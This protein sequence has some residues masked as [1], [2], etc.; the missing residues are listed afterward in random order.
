M[1]IVL[2]LSLVLLYSGCY[3]V[4]NLIETSSLDVQ[5]ED[6]NFHTDLGRFDEEFK[7]ASTKEQRNQ[8][9]DEL[10]TASNMECNSF[11]YKADSQP[12]EEVGSVYTSM[13]KIVGKYIGLDIAKDA[14]DAVSAVSEMGKKQNNQDKY[15]QALKP[16]IIKAVQISRKKYLQTIYSSKALDLEKYPLQ[17]V[18]EDLDNY[19]KHC[20]TYYGLLEINKALERQN[21]PTQEVSIIDIDEVK[22]KIKKVTKEVV[23]NKTCEVNIIK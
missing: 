9:I 20:S 17:K 22:T 13:F 11:L 5:K 7:T 1:K 16:N 19:D 4:P 12:K 10:V 21:T 3:E 6:K 23:A 14:I 15:A 2:L 8:L 18:K